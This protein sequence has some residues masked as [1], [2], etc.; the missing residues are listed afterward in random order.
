[1]TADLEFVQY[2]EQLVSG[3]EASGTGVNRSLERLAYG[4]DALLDT[5]QGTKGLFI[6][7]GGV[8][9]WSHATN[10]LTWSAH[11][12]F[13]FPHELGGAAWNRLPVESSHHRRFREGGLRRL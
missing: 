11:I 13:Y 5:V 2:L 1:M 4:L 3:S 8:I 7:G 12:Y 9:A 10:Q 6:T